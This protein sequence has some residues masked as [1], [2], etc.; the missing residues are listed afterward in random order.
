MRTKEGCDRGSEFEKVFCINMPPHHCGG[1]VPALYP[2]E[3]SKGRKAG[4]IS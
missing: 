4:Q 2:R 3:G 1:A